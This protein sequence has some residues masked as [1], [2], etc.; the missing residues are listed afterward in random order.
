YPAEHRQAG[1]EGRVVLQIVVDETGRV[2]EAEV[3]LSTPTAAFGEA[4]VASIL[5]WRFTPA[6]VGGKPVKVRMG[7]TMDFT[8]ADIPPG[9]PEAEAYM[10]PHSDWDQAPRLIHRV[11]PRYPEI[12]RNAG[13]VGRVILQIVVDETGKVIEAVPVVAEPPGIFEEAAIAAIRQWRFEPAL[14][15]GKPIKVRMGQLVEF[16]LDP[17]TTMPLAPVGCRG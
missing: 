11:S 14:K 2:T 4:A 17:L 5:Q 3:I 10:P 1:V 7:Q 9:K 8:L 15:D 12:A 13:V 16:K 6:R